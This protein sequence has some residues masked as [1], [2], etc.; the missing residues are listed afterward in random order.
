MKTDD[1]FG[2]WFAGFTDGEGCFVIAKNQVSYKC[3][4]V[5]SLR[6]DD[7]PVL[8]EIHDRF[9]IGKLYFTPPRVTMSR[10]GYSATHRATA[11]WS[12][13]SKSDVLRLVAIFDRY[14]LRAKKRN[15]YR[16][17]REAAMLWIERPGRCGPHRTIH[18]AQLRMAELKAELIA[19]R[20]LPVS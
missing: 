7:L 18:P 12:V 8:K 1:Q 6:V 3:L 10:P 5:I 2:Y 4:F 15:D 9:K 11:T 20:Q 13:Q 17:W 16:I 19:Q 14:P